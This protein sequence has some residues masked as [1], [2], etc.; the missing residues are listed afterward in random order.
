[1]TRTRPDPHE[2]YRADADG[3]TAPASG[4]YAVALAGTAIVTLLG[5]SGYDLFFGIDRLNFVAGIALWLT[6]FESLLAIVVAAAG[7]VAGRKLAATH[8][9]ALL[10][11]LLHLCLFALFMC[12]NLIGSGR[13]NTPSVPGGW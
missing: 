8:A 6:L 12:L 13:P 10:L 9:W 4:V 1:M 5:L 2:P 7:A 11:S 3:G